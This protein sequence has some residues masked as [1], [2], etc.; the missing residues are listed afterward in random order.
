MSRLSA[1]QL[2]CVIVI[3]ILVTGS[4]LVAIINRHKPDRDDR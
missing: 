3:T 4:V 2:F 1:Q